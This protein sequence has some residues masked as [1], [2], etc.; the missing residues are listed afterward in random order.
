MEYFVCSQCGTVDRG[1]K[2]PTGWGTL[3]DEL[4]CFDCLDTHRAFLKHERIEALRE[5][6]AKRTRDRNGEKEEDRIDSICDDGGHFRR[7]IPYPRTDTDHNVFG[8]RM[9]GRT[10]NLPPNEQRGKIRDA[11][12]ADKRARTR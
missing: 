4:L 5:G 7:Y 12:A 10:W 11:R 9:W 8:V 1:Y 3:H 2:E 6:R